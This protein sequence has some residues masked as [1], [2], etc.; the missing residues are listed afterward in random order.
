M[1]EPADAEQ[2]AAMR[3]FTRFYTRLIGLLNETLLR[4]GYSLAESRVL[5]EL[6]HRPAATASG[7]SSE[8]GM[9][10]GYLSRVL[11]RFEKAGHLDRTRSEAD[12]RRADL[13]LTPAGHEAFAPLNEGSRREVEAL[14]S[15]LSP[16]ERRELIAA[17]GRIEQLLGE[18]A[19]PAA[20]Y[21]LRPLQVGDVGWIAHRQGLLYAR[22]YGFDATYE[23]LVAE[24]AAAFAKSY[25]PRHESAWIAERQGQVVGSVFVVRVSDE[26]AK[27]RLLYVEPAARGL[28]VGRR[29]T[30]ECIRFARAKGYRTLTLW[31]NDV[32]TAARRIYAEIGFELVASEPHHSFGQD[33][34]GETWTLK[35]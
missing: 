14:L 19:E 22:E 33:L 4:S 25:D 27:L 30:Q 24:I 6:A 16:A 29:L 2:I 34:V 13:M 28:G 3:R 23:A 7:L 18:R 32:L 1:A 26:V 15:G 20:P 9:D 11:S 10:P 12:G 17:M 31:T 35:L 8:L 21:L 5:Y